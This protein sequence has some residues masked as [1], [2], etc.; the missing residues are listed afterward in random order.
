[1]VEDGA[2]VKRQAVRWMSSAAWHESHGGRQ[3]A[4]RPGDKGAIVLLVAA[5]NGSLTRL[6]HYWR[7]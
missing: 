5:V 3:S 4:R 7:P 1:M 6:S 2:R